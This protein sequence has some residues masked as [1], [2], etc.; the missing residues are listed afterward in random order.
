MEIKNNEITEEM[1]YQWLGSDSLKSHELVAL[2]TEIV[3]GKYL[4]SDF[5]NDVLEYAEVLND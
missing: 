5:A 4:V 2:L 1:V 3:N